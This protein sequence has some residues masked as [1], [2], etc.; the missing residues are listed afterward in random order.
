MIIPE[1]LNIPKNHYLVHNYY[2]KTM[3]HKVLLNETVLENLKSECYSANLSSDEV[4][5]N[6]SKRI[7]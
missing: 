5:K 2:T 3:Y 1:H 7:I 4:I 6:I